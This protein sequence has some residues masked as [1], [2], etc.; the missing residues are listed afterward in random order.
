MR[1][2]PAPRS[3]HSRAIPRKCSCTAGFALASTGIESKPNQPVVVAHAARDGLR[4]ELE[5]A[6]ERRAERLAGAGGREAVVAVERRAVGAHVVEDAVEDHADPALARLLDEL[7]EL[8]LVAEPR[9]DP[10]VVGGVVAVV[11]VRLEDRVEVDR[12]DAELLQVVELLPDALEVAAEVVAAVRA[13]AARLGRGVVAA[14]ALREVVPRLLRRGER[15]VADRPDRRVVLR[16]RV[17]EAVREDLVDDRV[18]R[19]GRRGGSRARTPSGPSCGPRRRRWWRRG[20]R[21]ARPCCRR[22]SRCRSRP[23][24]RTGTR[25]CSP[26]AFGSSTS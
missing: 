2:P 21:R 3:S 19:P 25:G 22:S 14:V 6:P 13:L 20:R 9:V 5:P 4:Q 12:G 26:S 11:R 16:V 17:L 15:A 8:L 23:R 10:R 24:R 1:Q 18:P 7:L